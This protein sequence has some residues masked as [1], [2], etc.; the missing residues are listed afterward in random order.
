M[1]AA[2]QSAPAIL[3]A[4]AIG[5]L[6][7]VC[8]ALSYAELGAAIPRNGGEFQLLSRIYH[9]LLGFL[10]GWVALVVGFAAPLAFYAHV[11]GD[12]LSQLWPVHP[13]AAGTGLI[14]VF[15]VTHS[16]SVGQG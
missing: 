9:P 5:G 7:A 4:W 11:F 3:L 15:A 16:L 14:L 13:V 8:G 12:Y 1:V 6:A 2:L 10:A